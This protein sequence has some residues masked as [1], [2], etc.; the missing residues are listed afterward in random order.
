G[1]DGDRRQRAQSGD[2]ERQP[3]AARLPFEQEVVL[4]L[5]LLHDV[6]GRVT[7]AV[8]LHPVQHL[9]DAVEAGQFRRQLGVAGP[10]GGDVIGIIALAGGMFTGHAWLP[11]FLPSPPSTG[12]RGAKRS[13]VSHSVPRRACSRSMPSNGALKLPLPKL[14]EPR[15]W[16]TSKN[17]VGRSATGLVK[18]CSMYP[19]SS[20]S[21]RMP[22]SANS[23]RFSLI[24]PTRSVSES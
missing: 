19:S 14:R 16:I 23:L 1:P 20:R 24:G 7:P 8:P 6:D 15:R 10:Q 12:A 4:E 5:V 18:I 3:R 13:P 11:S 17:S 22:S 21:T 2:A 9:L